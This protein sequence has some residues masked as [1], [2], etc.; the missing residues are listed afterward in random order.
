MREK[1]TAGSGGRK[2]KE[3]D[4]DETRNNGGSGRDN[5]AVMVTIVCGTVISFILLAI[6]LAIVC[7]K[8]YAHPLLM[9]N[10]PLISPISLPTK[11]EICQVPML[12]SF[13]PS[14]LFNYL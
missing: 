8:W 5:S 2:E 3:S 14:H 7:M 13:L 9:L 10:T 11:Q 12:Q 4:K 1:L 6:L